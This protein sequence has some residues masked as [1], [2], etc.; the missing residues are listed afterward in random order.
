MGDI[1][2]ALYLVWGVG[3]AGMV[4]ACVSTL[5]CGWVLFWFCPTI[6]VYVSVVSSLVFGVI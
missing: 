4:T 6:L 1:V 3:Y 5:G 2:L